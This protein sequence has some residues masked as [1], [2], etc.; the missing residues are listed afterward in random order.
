MSNIH[1]TGLTMMITAQD[2]I[3]AQAFYSQHQDAQKG[4]QVYL[5]TLA[6]RV[7]D[8]YLKYFGIESDLEN[9]A[10]SDPITQ[11]LLD[12]AAL[13]ITDVGDIECRPVLANETSVYVPEEVQSD[14]LGYV[15]VQ[16]DNQLETATLL[17]FISG[18]KEAYV[19]F[20]KLQP[21]ET[22]LDVAVS[23]TAVFT[24][25]SYWLQATVSDGWQLVED[26]FAQPNPALSFRGPSDILNSKLEAEDVIRGRIITLDATDVANPL[27]LAVGITPSDSQEWGIWVR[28]VPAGGKK[29]LPYDLELKLLDETGDSLMQAQSRETESIGLKFMGAVGDHFS[30]QISSS[31][32]AHTEHFII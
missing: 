12:T 18:T 11:Q 2:H 15:A 9:S 19:A 4:K 27:L 29:H 31:D 21:V 5:N 25:L 32:N 28:V 30:V 26:I 16:L 8:R 17:G 14:R 1:D 23:P 20:S 10:S 3:T 7:V 13:H 6:V 24:K 22:V